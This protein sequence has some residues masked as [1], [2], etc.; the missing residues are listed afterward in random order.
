MPAIFVPLAIYGLLIYYSTV[1]I[2]PALRAVKDW[3][4]PHTLIP[5]KQLSSC[6]NSIALCYITAKVLR[7][8]RILGRRIFALLLSYFLFAL[9]FKI[10][11]YCYSSLTFQTEVTSSLLFPSLLN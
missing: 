7:H 9:I 4:N 6:E 10:I 2:I 1:H 8:F 5:I 11:Q 3:L